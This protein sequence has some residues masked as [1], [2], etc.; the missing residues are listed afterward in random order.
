MGPHGSEEEETRPQ[1]SEEL[2]LG[3]VLCMHCGRTKED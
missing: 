3:D 1:G 2:M